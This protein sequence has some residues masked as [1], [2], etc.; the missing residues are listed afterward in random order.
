MPAGHLGVQPGLDPAGE[1]LLDPGEGGVWLVECA[2]LSLRSHFKH[3]PPA[4]L[5]F[6][7]LP[8]KTL[9]RVT[10]GGNTKSVFNLL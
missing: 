5:F 8:M 9:Q 10:D 3:S 4:R 7:M 6:I 2:W 1:E